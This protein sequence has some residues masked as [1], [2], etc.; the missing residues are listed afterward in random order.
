MGDGNEI[1]DLIFDSDSDDSDS[2]DYNTN[3]P[4]HGRRNSSDSSGDEYS[5]DSSNDTEINEF[6]AF[7]RKFQNKNHIDYE[8]NTTVTGGNNTQELEVLTMFPYLVR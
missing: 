3:K 1:D 5:D 4:K 2:S 7:I 8:D 6:T